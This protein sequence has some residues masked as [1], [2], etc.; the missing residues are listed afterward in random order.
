MRDDPIRWSTMSRRIEIELTSARPDGT[1]T[2][3]AAGAR[4]PRGVVDSSVL[5]EASKVGDVLRVEAESDLDGITILG[6]VQGRAKHDPANVL[7]LLPDEKPFEAVTQQLAPKQRDSRDRRPGGRD[8]HD[9]GERRDGKPRDGKPRDGKP[10]DGKPRE[11]RDGREARDSRDAR[12]GRDPRDGSPSDRR[13]RPSRP[14]RPSFTPPPDLPARPKAKRLKPGRVHRNEV[15]AELPEAQRPVAERVLQGGIPAVRQAVKEQNERLAAEGQEQI[16]ADNL[17]SMAEHLL[18][19][20]RVAEWRDRADAALRDIDHLDLRDLRS[21]VAASEDPSVARDAATREIAVQLR[22]ALIVKQEREYQQWLEDIDAALGVGRV[23]RAFKLSSQ[24]PKAGVPFPPDTAVKLATAGSAALTPEDTSER[25]SAV[26][27]AVAFSPVRSLV[28]PTGLPP[29]P[30][31]DLLAT[32]KRL[33]GLLP[34]I[35]GQ[36][37]VESPKPGAPTPKPLRPTRPTSSS[38]AKGRP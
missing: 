30:S 35:A 28:K 6:V 12:S 24:P 26:L 22:E 16:P 3:R 34:D 14:P 36:F 2:W 1:W 9:A 37:G 13:D 8:R 31:A 17:L 21:V 19:R 15:L 18:P 32:V 27:E 33:A 11:G 4:E 10:R 7:A 29:E 5:P 23:I 38:A 20:L 25:W